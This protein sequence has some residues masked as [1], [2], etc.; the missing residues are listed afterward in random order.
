[1]CVYVSERVCVRERACVCVCRGG[2]SQSGSSCPSRPLYKHHQSPLAPHNRSTNTISLLLP[3][4][5]AL[6]TP[7]VSTCPSR[8]LYKH[9]QSPLAPHDR[10]TNT[11]SLLL[12]LRTALQTPS[13]FYL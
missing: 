4:T 9:H 7:S 3:L 10:S 8:P 1:M 11:I 6:Q 5:T 2:G 12:P 13:V